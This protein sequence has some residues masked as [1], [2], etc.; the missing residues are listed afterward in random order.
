MASEIN[1]MFPDCCN[2]LPRHCDPTGILS[3]NKTLELFRV[4]RFRSATLTLPSAR[5]LVRVDRASPV[6]EQSRIG[7]CRLFLFSLSPIEP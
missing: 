1:V 5:P 4:S 7:D 2:V 6:T 3:E